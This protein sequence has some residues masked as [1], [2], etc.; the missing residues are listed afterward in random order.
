METAKEC[1]FLWT[2]KWNTSTCQKYLTEETAAVK[3]NVYVSWSTV[4]KGNM[5]APFSTATL[6]KCT[7]EAL[8]LSQ[9]CST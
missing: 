2:T 4:V 9:D 1:W 8:L 7:E 5:K 3:K 6:P